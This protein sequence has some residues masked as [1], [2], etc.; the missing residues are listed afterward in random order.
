MEIGF[1]YTYK[2]NSDII[3]AIAKISEFSEV[4]FIILGAI[5]IF[6]SVG[7]YYLFPI[8]YLIKKFFDR[9]KEKA[10]RKFMLKQISTQ[11]EIEDEIE[12]EI[13]VTTQAQ[14]ELNNK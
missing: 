3:A 14:A 13:E 10:K 6:I 5:I 4:Q 8:I 12:A 1:E 9:Q 7:V 11:R 2:E